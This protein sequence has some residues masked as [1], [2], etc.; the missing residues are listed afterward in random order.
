MPGRATADHEPAP[1]VKLTRAEKAER[2][3]ARLFHAA[4]ET[5]GERGY[6]DT[7]IAKI[8]ERARVALGTF[9]NYFDSR[10]DIL[11]QLLPAMGLELIALIRERLLL[12]ED[13]AARERARLEAFFDFLV[14]H[15]S[16]YRI[17]NE[18]EMF[19]PVGF[20]QH[21][22]NMVRSYKTVL[23]TET[24]AAVDN[25]YSEVHAYMLLAARN[26]LAMRYSVRNGDVRRPPAYVI[27]AYMNLVTRGIFSEPT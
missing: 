8:T 27:D 3:R 6:A 2:T 10:Q 4:T 14:D 20:R 15:P 19:A 5:V 24:R 16:F 12:V 21:M 17:L 25:E 11:D 7:S 23:R 26:Y 9:Y 1:P 13:P 18:A 22:E